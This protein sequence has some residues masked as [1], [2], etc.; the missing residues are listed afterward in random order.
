[1][2]NHAGIIKKAILTP[3][4]WAADAIKGLITESLLHS[5]AA[6]EVREFLSADSLTESENDDFA[7]SRYPPEYLKTVQRTA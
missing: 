2:A 4:N 7:A 3:T 1:V 6:H 5:E